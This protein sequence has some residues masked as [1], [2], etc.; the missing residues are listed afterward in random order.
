MS[1]IDIFLLDNI[2]NIKEKMNIIKP[3]IYEKLMNQL[4]N[5]LNNNIQ[6]SYEIFILDKNDKE[7][8]INNEEEYN[9]IDNLIFIRSKNNLNKSM[10]ELNN[11][12]L[13]KLKDQI[14]GEKNNCSLCSFIIKKEKPYLCYKC[15][16]II[17]EKFLNN[18][19]KNLRF[20]NDGP[21]KQLKMKKVKK[22]M[23]I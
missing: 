21:N 13:T 23:M 5:K 19:T 11:N 6:N 16:K 2:N 17:N 1:K 8:K 10:N 3:N 15:Q 18:L 14:L 7:L 9:K 20:Q 22:I 12:L 4:K